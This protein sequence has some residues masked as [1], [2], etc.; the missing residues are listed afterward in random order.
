MFIRALVLTDAHRKS[1][2]NFKKILIFE[3]LEATSATQPLKMEEFDGRK[4]E[5]KREMINFP[6]DY[7]IPGTVIRA[8]LLR[9]HLLPLQTLAVAEGGPEA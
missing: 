9:Q 6:Y 1:R 7:T 2:N 8:H 3:Y 4:K 5:T